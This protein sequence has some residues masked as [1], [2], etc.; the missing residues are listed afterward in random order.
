M[1][2][3]IGTDI[4]E[5]ARVA[6]K[7]QRHRG[8]RDFVFSGNEIAYC[9]KMASKFEH[10]AARFAAKEAF[11]KALGTGWQSGTAFN[12]IEVVHNANGQP[13]IILLE[14]TKATLQK[15]PPFQIHLSLSHIKEFA[16]AFVMIEK[17]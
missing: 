6:D 8:F 17:L 12:E 11:L 7:I 10:Y 16:V 9:E 5:V 3:G 13:E 14:N 15:L 4:I 1:T 2:M